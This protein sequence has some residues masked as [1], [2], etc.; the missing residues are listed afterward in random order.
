MQIIV[1]LLMKVLGTLNA[2]TG[3]YGLALVLFAVL[4]KIAL[5]GPTHQQYKSMKQMQKIQPEIEALQKKYA[6]DKEAAMQAQ[7][8]FY[9]S[10]GINPLS[11]CLP[12]LIQMPILFSIWQAIMGAPDLFSNSYF[13]WIHPGPLQNA[14][15]VLF[16]S[17]LA[18]RD[19][20]LVIFYGLTMLLSQLITPASGQGSQKYLGLFMSVIFTVMMW[21]YKWPCALILYFSVFSFLTIIQQG[22]IMRTPDEEEQQSAAA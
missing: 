18:D 19:L 14:Y 22:I 15:P 12:M 1:D 13:L 21:T 17:S 20:P 11:G 7:T 6:H 4:I 16:A 10:R 3:S 9:Q 8:E 2:L 5:Y